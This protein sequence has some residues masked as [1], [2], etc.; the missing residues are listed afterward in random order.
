MVTIREASQTDAGEMA[1]IQTE[2]LRRRARDHYT[3]DQLR[4]LAPPDPDADAIPEAEFTD[5]THHAIV[6]EETGDIVGWGSIHLDRQ[7]LAATFVDPESVGSGIGRAIVDRLETVARDAGI[8]EITV[9]ASVNAVGFYERLG[10]ETQREIDA[11]TPETP[12][13]PGVEMTKQLD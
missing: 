3:D 10:Y 7:T 12:E 5:D 11:G 8:E 1:R 4:H 6:A 13:I 9:P 2:A